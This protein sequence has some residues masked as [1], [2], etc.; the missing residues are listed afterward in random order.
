[1]PMNLHVDEFVFRQF[2][3]H[4]TL[5]VNRKIAKELN[6][7]F[8]LNDFSQSKQ[9]FFITYKF[10][11]FVAVSFRASFAYMI[12]INFKTIYHNIRTVISH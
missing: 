9:N 7:I 12:K 3:V 4:I 10:L 2:I 5:H 1:M 6:R 11:T 8:V